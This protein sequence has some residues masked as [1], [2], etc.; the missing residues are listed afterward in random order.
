MSQRQRSA[1]KREVIVQ[2]E[3]VKTKVSF[4][5][6]TGSSVSLISKAMFGHIQNRMSL[7]VK[8]VDVSL[9][10]FSRN[11][12][13][14][15][16][17]VIV[18]V[19]LAGVHSEW[20]FIVTNLLDTDFLL[21]SDF[22]E[23]NCLSLDMGKGV[24]RSAVGQV[25]FSEVPVNLNECLKIRTSEAISIAPNKLVWMMAEV[26]K[27][28]AYRKTYSGTVTPDTAL[29]AD[30]GLIVAASIVNTEGRRVPV[31]CV[32]AT[33]ETIHLNKNRLLGILEPLDKTYATS[34]RIRGVRTVRSVQKQDYADLACSEGDRQIQDRF[35]EWTHEKLF[36]DLKIEDID[37][38]THDEK[39]RMKE[40]VWK[41]RKCFSRNSNDIGNC[42][43][44]EAKIQ[45]RKD[46]T[47]QWVPSIHVPYKLQSA[48]EEHVDGMM[49]A[50]VIAKIPKEAKSNWNSRVF[51][52]PK[53]NRKGQFRF[54][55]DMRSVNSQCLPD[56]FEI[57]NVN[58]VADRIGGRKLYS[59]CDLSQSFHQISYDEESRAIA[60]FSCNGSRYWYKRMIMGHKASGS[61]FSR[62]MYKLLNGIPVE[63]LCY[64]LDD[65]MLAT[66][67]F[68]SHMKLLETVLMRFASANLK[69]MPTK[70]SFLKREVKFVGLTFSG[71]GV[72]IND[73]RV[74]A[75]LE[76][77]P[78]KTSKETRSVLGFFGYNRKFI[79]KY[80]EITRPLYALLVKGSRFKWTE[81]CQAAF[82]QLKTAVSESTM[83]A[84]PETDDPHQ[85]YEV[86]IDGSNKGY[87]AT[88]SQLIK[89]QRRIVAYYSKKVPP[90]K[91][92]W[93]QTK[94]E[95]QTLCKALD[96]WKVYLRGTKFV[97][98]TDCDSLLDIETIFGKE[99]AMM[100]RKCQVLSNYDFTLRHIA[101]KENYMSDFLSR[102]P[103]K[104]RMKEQGTQ[105]EN[106]SVGVP[107]GMVIKAITSSSD[108][109]EGIREELDI[110]EVDDCLPDITYLF[111]H[112]GDDTDLVH[113]QV[114]TN[115][116]VTGQVS[117]SITD[118]EA[119]KCLC[120]QFKEEKRAQKSEAAEKITRWE[121][122]IAR[123]E[124]IPTS[125]EKL[126]SLEVIQAAQEVDPIL[127][128]V[129][130]W[131]ESKEKPLAVQATRTPRDILSYWKQ[132]NL[133]SLEDGLLKRKWI[134]VGDEDVRDLVIIPEKLQEEA[135]KTIHCSEI[136]RH[137]GV[138]TSIAVCSKYYYW[139]GMRTDIKLFV[140]ACVTCGRFK[141][142]SA[143]LKAPL[144]H[145]LFHKFN[146]AVNIDHI[147]PS[148]TRNPR[149]F[150]HIL[151]ISDMWSNYIVAVPCMGE[152]GKETI[153]LLKKHWFYK[154]GWPNEVIS[155]NGPGY[156]SDHFNETLKAHGCKVTK[157]TPHLAR[158]TGR[159]ESSNKRLDTILRTSIPEGKHVDWDEYLDCVVFTLNGLKGRN[160]GYSANRLVYGVELRT[161]LD[162]IVR[163]GSS[164]REDD[165]AG[166][167]SKDVQERHRLTKSIITKVRLNSEQSFKYA[168]TA[169]NKGLKGPY[170]E[171]GDYVYM[172]IH[173]PQH[174]FSIRWQGPVRIIKVIS[175]H[176]YV[177]LDDEGSE[178]VVNIK[179]LKRYKK[180]RF[181]PSEIVTEETVT[182]S[183]TLNPNAREFSPQP[184]PGDVGNSTTEDHE[185]EADNQ[186]TCSSSA[187]Y[188]DK[189]D[190]PDYRESSE[191]DD[192]EYDDAQ[193]SLDDLD[194]RSEMEHDVTGTNLSEDQNNSLRSEEEL[195]TETISDETE[196]N[197]SFLEQ[198]NPEH[199]DQRN[200]DPE[201][202][203]RSVR[204]RKEVI[205][206]EVQAQKEAWRMPQ[207]E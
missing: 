100:Q 185:T 178:K 184:E 49:Q 43:F 41:Y 22:M 142:P 183:Q 118:G 45:L 13:P 6:D 38:I 26:P 32:N 95:F 156:G 134:P 14:T 207:E 145:L 204:A 16:G 28:Y 69:L 199:P 74:A 166:A 53:P 181:S 36:S 124:A 31:Q 200:T 188:D 186:S 122:S 96:Y 15:Y 11:T 189:Y 155:D 111:D 195:G 167:Y 161:P 21:G 27:A 7:E 135:M 140:E 146:D 101:G 78:P 44:Y 1:R 103:Y 131:V 82:D 42:N 70:C 102:Y 174:K 67:D 171:V 60:A 136:G 138:A 8:S 10:S 198:G 39:S 66:D 149:G 61:H 25:E 139:P 110:S 85:S 165:E 57:P 47:P 79:P 175:I 160:T 132:F 93:G 113:Q 191:D 144:Q 87:A 163:R 81:E 162:L 123:I 115:A 107:N 108:P 50:D 23:E 59:T 83:L 86:T 64:F 84:I 80:A 114:P 3:C 94:L 51:L 152:T 4:F 169:W 18:P 125:Q 117:S 109:A 63:H 46:A 29:T 150:R 2:G 106:Q 116:S 90:H 201:P 192:T 182:E 34:T 129:K 65:L 130:K 55:A 76:I 157:G 121:L 158:S 88:L 164:T 170:F 99:S 72:R 12:I 196:L 33:D 5:L 173:C 92:E 37:T 137:P 73:E 17:Q 105:T 20:R 30:T 119:P 180:N 176:L 54:V 172:L 179:H 35:P 9:T 197:N 147:T 112:S 194:M 148:T 187:S 24:L 75:L 202:V 205:Y 206:N 120:S 62:M 91:R 203:R 104:R 97:V 77:P 48:M 154:Y 40:L 89:A 126:L 141:Q 159:A 143:Y 68:D 56:S 151:T 133:L 58:M 177:I 98:I 71:E 153:Q 193:S 190:D 128:E 127:I 52:V 19:T 168:E